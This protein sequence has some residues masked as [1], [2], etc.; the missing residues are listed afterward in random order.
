MGESAGERKKDLQNFFSQHPHTF[1]ILSE[2]FRRVGKELKKCTFSSGW[3]WTASWTKDEELDFKRWM[4]GYLL[5]HKQAVC[6]L[7][8][9]R[10]VSKYR[11][12]TFLQQLVDE[13]I[14]QYGWKRKI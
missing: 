11:N 12:R 9:T 6:E 10:P 2:M 8:H 4:V 7:T 5:E 3:F 14:W 13:F 1:H